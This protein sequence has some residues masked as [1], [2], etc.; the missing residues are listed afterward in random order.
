[1]RQLLS[2]TTILMCFL[3]LPVPEV[4]VGLKGPQK[5]HEDCCQ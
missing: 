2:L 5:A 3:R 4:E 1:M